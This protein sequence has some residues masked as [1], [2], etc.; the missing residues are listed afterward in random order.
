MEPAYDSVTYDPLKTRLS[1][2]TLGEAW[3][4]VLGFRFFLR[5][6]LVPNSP[7]RFS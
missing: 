5:L 3:E 1:E 6:I 4:L 2:E 7:F